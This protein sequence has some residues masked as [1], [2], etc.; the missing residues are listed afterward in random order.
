V[1]TAPDAEDQF[2]RLVEAYAVLKDERRRARYDAF[3]GRRT[4][5]S[6][7]PRSGDRVRYED[8]RVGTD[9][10]HSSFDDFVARQRARPSRPRHVEVRI[11]LAEA[12][13]GTTIDVPL[14]SGRSAPLRVEIP[15]GAKSG[16]RLP[17]Q[18]HDVVL[19]LRIES[20]EGVVLDGRD[21]KMSA[22]ITPWEAALGG[23]V[24]IFAPHRVLKVRIPP[25]TS[26]GR[27]LR[28]KGQGLPQ[29]PG[30]RGPPGDL[31]AEVRIEVPPELTPDEQR[32]FRRL[33]EVSR[34]DPRPSDD[35]LPRD[36]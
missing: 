17:L 26:S 18:D 9:D 7:R 25:G 29:K 28:I 6:R 1:N 21:V 22:P 35:D 19:T 30:R 34:F 11:G 27:V 16:D 31:Y 23:T 12:Y 14:G 4:R 10:L 32:L 5:R 20:D 24:G 33:A 15:P 36:G 8:V 13:T 2:K 3:G